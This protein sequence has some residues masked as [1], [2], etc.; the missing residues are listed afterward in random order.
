M[1]TIQQGSSRSQDLVAKLLSCEDLTIRSGNFHTAM[2]DTKNRVLYMPRLKAGKDLYDLFVAHEVG[3][4]LYTPDL[5]SHSCQKDVEGIPRAYLN[6]IEDVRI[7]ARIQERFPGLKYV[8]RRGYEETLDLDFFGIDEMRRNGFNLNTLPLIDKI[9]L[10]TKIGRENVPEIMFNSTEEALLK[11]AKRCRTFKQVV[12]VCKELLAYEKSKS[13]TMKDQE[14]PQESSQGNGDQDGQRKKKKIKVKIKEKDDS[15]DGEDKGSKGKKSPVKAED[16]EDGGSY[17]AEMGNEETPGSGKESDLEIE[18]DAEGGDRGER[19]GSSDADSG[20]S[21]D[22]EGGDTGNDR[23]TSITDDNYRKNEACIIDTSNFTS[24]YV[25]EKRIEDHVIL[26]VDKFLEHFAGNSFN[27]ENAENNVN[28][29]Y[30]S[31]LKKNKSFITRLGQEFEMR[32]VAHRLAQGVTDKTG[33]LNVNDLHKYRFSDDIFK[34]KVKFPVGKNHGI[35]LLLDFSSSMCGKITDV[36]YQT[37]LLVEFC[38]MKNIPYAVY[39]FTSGGMVRKHK[40]G[41]NYDIT[42]IDFKDTH[43]FEITRS[44]CPKSMRDL[45]DLYMFW[46]MKRYK[47]DEYG[48]SGN[49]THLPYMGGTPL[50]ESLLVMFFRCQSLKERWRV[51]RFHFIT[52]TDGDGNPRFSYLPRDPNR[53]NEYLQ[54]GMVNN[55]INNPMEITYGNHKSIKYDQT[56]SRGSSMWTHMIDQFNGFGNT[57]GYFLSPGVDICGYTGSRNIGSRN[58]KLSQEDIQ[59]HQGSFDSRGFTYIPGKYCGYNDYLFITGETSQK[60][61][62]KFSGDNSLIQEEMESQ[63]KKRKDSRA[64]AVQ[65]GKII[66]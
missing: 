6:V 63:L 45:S 5:G 40:V 31:F 7:E 58:R 41:T 55:P 35:C 15:K 62:L 20:S 9:N 50:F 14:L 56:I 19:Q 64:L 22:H 38:K 24:L 57:I 34:R 1:K 13:R 25:D 18:A 54:S 28:K 4:A 29:S 43:L 33:M 2:F 51:E 10:D 30:Q 23:M 32:K 42:N 46:M 44:D 26:P 11:K 60:V 21:Y 61:N 12:E 65:I 8:M 48:V 59:R 52:L 27:S 3:H 37:I 53:H 47:G 66:G 17:E 36:I 16:L 39:G 49:G